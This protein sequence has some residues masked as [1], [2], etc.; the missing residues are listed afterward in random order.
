MSTEGHAVILTFQCVEYLHT[1]IKNDRRL[2]SRI[3]VLE[4]IPSARPKLIFTAEGIQPT[5]ASALVKASRAWP[6]RWNQ[7]QQRFYT[8]RLQKQGSVSVFALY[9]LRFEESL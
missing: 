2:D 6:R 4:G 9:D 3:C 5:D 1:L 8:S 7:P